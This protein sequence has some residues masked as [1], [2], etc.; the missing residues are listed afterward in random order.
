MKRAFWSVALA[1]AGIATSGR[2]HAQ[3]VDKIETARDRVEAKS[4]PRMPAPFILPDL[5]HHS[6]DFSVDWWLG[7]VGVEPGYARTHVY[8]AMGRVAMEA[9]IVIPRRLY[10]GWSFPFGFG[11]PPDG[12]L[13]QTEP[14]RPAGM[15]RFTGNAEAHIR[16]VFPLPTWLEIGFSMGLMFPTAAF[17]RDYRPNISGTRVVTTLDPTSYV[18]FLPGRFGFRPAGDLRITRGPLVFQGRHGIDV[19]F[20]N[21]SLSGLIVAG[22]LLAHVGYVARPDLEVA[23][24]AQQFYFFTSEDPSSSSVPAERDFFESYR[25]KD[26]RRSAIALG[27]TIRAMTHYYDYGVAVVTNLENPLS[28]IASGF[29][30]VRF[31]IIGHISK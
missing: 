6:V 26:G 1:V 7:R 14:A 20:D 3:I 27:P 30:G 2:A 28:P 8:A 4:P 10:V 29:I 11:L 19:M 17:D 18:D 5:A 16:T 23:V 24:E 21:Q 13:A 22:R 12:G 25:Q 31:S 9:N 15:R